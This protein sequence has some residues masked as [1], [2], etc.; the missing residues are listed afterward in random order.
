MYNRQYYKIIFEQKK[1]DIADTA[2]RFLQEHKELVAK[3]K[4][5][6][7]VGGYFAVT[8]FIPRAINKHIAE[9]SFYDPDTGLVWRSRRKLSTA[10]RLAVENRVLNCEGIGEVLESMGILKH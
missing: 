8:V 7:I 4:F 3:C 1:R 10:E 6:A 9:T 5:A 2:S